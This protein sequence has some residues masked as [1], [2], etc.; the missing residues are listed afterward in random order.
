V[1]PDL[2]AA[3]LP[4]LGSARLRSHRLSLPTRRLLHRRLNTPHLPTRSLGTRRLAALSLP[5][6]RLSG[7]S[8]GGLCLSD[9]G[10]SWLS[11]P[12]TL[13]PGGGLSSCWLGGPC[14]WL[15]RLGR[16]GACL[17]D[18]WPSDRGLS[19]CLARSRLCVG[20]LACLRLGLLTWL[21]LPWLLTAVLRTR[22]GSRVLRPHR[23]LTGLLRI[24]LLRTQLP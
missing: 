8:L 3:W 15:C 18:R 14:L 16:S 21:G 1:V 4:G 5:R 2:R 10:L 11:L 19:G 7:L 9:P 23:L 13:L 24:R 12:K 20:L 6:L 17:P 22:R